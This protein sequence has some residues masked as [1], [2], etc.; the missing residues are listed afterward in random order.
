VFA[1]YQSLNAEQY[2][3]AIVKSTLTHEQLEIINLL[4][5]KYL[6]PDFIINLLVDYTLFKT[7]GVLN[8]KYITKTAQ[9][10]NNLGLKSLTNVYDH[11]H[12]ANRVNY[13]LE[14]PKA[15]VQETLVE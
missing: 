11:F 14:T 10:I 5:S 8:N 6:L 9:T 2:L 4:R 3:R 1:D 7:N 13:Q 15:K 12:F